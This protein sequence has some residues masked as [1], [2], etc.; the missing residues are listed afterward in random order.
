MRVTNTG[1]VSSVK[2]CCFLLSSL[3]FG[4]SSRGKSLSLSVTQ[5]VNIS[6]PLLIPSA[7]EVISIT[8]GSGRLTPAAWSAKR[9][10]SSSWTWAVVRMPV[11][12]CHQLV[13]FNRFKYFTTASH[14]TVYLLNPLPWRLLTRSKKLGIIQFPYFS[15]KICFDYEDFR[16]VS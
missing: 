3:L 7:R 5:T 6:C 8:R 1:L 2:T 11:T 15:C 9:C 14:S 12:V 16:P 13:F 10:S 4:S